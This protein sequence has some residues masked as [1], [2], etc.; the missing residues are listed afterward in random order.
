[1]ISVEHASMLEVLTHCYVPPHPDALPKMREA[2]AAALAEIRDRRA[3][4]AAPSP[5]PG[6]RLAWEQVNEAVSRFDADCLW[7]AVIKYGDDFLLE[8]GFPDSRKG[9]AA[10][11]VE[12]AQVE[13]EA[14]LRA[15]FAAGLAALSA[16]APAMMTLERAVDIL[17]RNEHRARIN[18]CVN[19]EKAYSL[20]NE[21][22]PTHLIAPLEAIAIAEKYER[23]AP[24]PAQEG[25]AT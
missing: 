7:M 23:D 13:A 12:A 8:W 15:F 19:Y 21:V 20:G 2:A 22:C 17:N 16:P 1:M 11:D 5:H 14:R 25:A 4:E 24:A 6:P 10:K 9:L 18:W 3:A